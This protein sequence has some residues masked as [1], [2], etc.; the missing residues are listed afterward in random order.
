MTTT[1]P[2]IAC[3]LAPQDFT[4]RAAWI[5]ALN[6]KS[7]RGHHLDDLRL[8]LIYALEARDEVLEMMRGE[9]ACCAFLAFEVQEGPDEIRLIIQ[10]PEAAQEAAELVFATLRA[11]TAND[12]SCGCCGGGAN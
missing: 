4:A 5:A 8:E 10:A 11:A 6:A 1:G 7:L 3:T 9:E 2:P 12:P